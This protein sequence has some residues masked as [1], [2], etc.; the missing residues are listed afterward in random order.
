MSC[1]KFNE[2]RKQFIPFVDDFFINFSLIIHEKSLNIPYYLENDFENNLNFYV[3]CLLLDGIFETFH[4]RSRER[5]RMI[6]NICQNQSKESSLPYLYVVG[7]AKFLI[8]VMPI[9]IDD[10]YKLINQY[11]IR[12]IVTMSKLSVNDKVKTKF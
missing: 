1:L 12:L 3:L 8:N 9:V 6:N 2:Y 11:T 5:R 10:F 4:I 7:L